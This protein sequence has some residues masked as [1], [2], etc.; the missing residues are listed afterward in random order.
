VLVLYKK[1]VVRFYVQ[2]KERNREGG[3]KKKKETTT[4]VEKK[5]RNKSQPEIKKKKKENPNDNLMR[6][7]TEAFVKA[8]SEERGKAMQTCTHA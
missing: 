5:C 2:T 8:Q 3:R 6:L 4:R 1:G 7:G